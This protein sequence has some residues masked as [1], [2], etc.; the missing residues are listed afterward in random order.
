MHS[1]A[2]WLSMSPGLSYLGEKVKYTGG[3]GAL[4]SLAFT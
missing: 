3:G 1:H 4:A 2:G